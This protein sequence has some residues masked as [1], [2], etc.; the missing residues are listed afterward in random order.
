MAMLNFGLNLKRWKKYVTSILHV[1][2]NWEALEGLPLK[3]KFIY[4]K[5]ASG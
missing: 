2:M 1:R 4:N 5:F 3:V